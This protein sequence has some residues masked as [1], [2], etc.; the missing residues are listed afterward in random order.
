MPARRQTLPFASTTSS[1][2]HCAT[3]LA[4]PRQVPG[5]AMP[6][7][8]AQW[9]RGALHL[10]THARAGILQTPGREVSCARSTRI[11]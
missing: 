6:V 7:A 8:R 1:L 9:M 4:S 5:G 3:A 10:V 11:L 2:G